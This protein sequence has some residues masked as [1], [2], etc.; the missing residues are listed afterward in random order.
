MSAMELPSTWRPILKRALNERTS[1]EECPPLDVLQ[2][3][4]GGCDEW[5][6]A[7]NHDG[8]TDA[9]RWLTSLQ[10]RAAEYLPS[11]APTL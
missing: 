8:A 11:P 10:A 5:L 6:P 3:E 7:E 1:V 4:Y 9:R 2:A